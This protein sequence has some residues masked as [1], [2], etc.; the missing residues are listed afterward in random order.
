M[1]DELALFA[2]WKKK[3]QETVPEKG[4]FKTYVLTQAQYDELSEY[5]EDAFYFIEEESE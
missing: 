3:L 4:W 1:I 5:E 2:L